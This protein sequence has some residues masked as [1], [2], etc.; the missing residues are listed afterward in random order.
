M[1]FFVFFVDVIIT[2]FRIIFIFVLYF[3]LFF[4]FFLFCYFIFFFFFFFS[5]RRRH[6]RWTGDWSSDVCSSDLLLALRVLL[7][8]GGDTVRYEQMIQEAWNGTN[9]SR[10]TVDVTISEIRK[11]LG[12]FGDRKSVV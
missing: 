11:T 2:F 1:S 3:K 7:R 5:S 8:H 9:V 6:T 12:E 4:F 10:H